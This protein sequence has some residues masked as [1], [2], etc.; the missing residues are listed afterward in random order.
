MEQELKDAVWTKSPFSGANQGNCVEIAKLSGG[1][2]A[3]R[4]SKDQSGPA[5]AFTPS[6]WAAFTQWV[7]SDD[8]V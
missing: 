5:L 2:V 3:V 6:E 4:D 1:R 8:T 7:R